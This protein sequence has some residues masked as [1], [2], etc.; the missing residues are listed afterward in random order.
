[1][2]PLAW[3]RSACILPSVTAVWNQS[4]PISS[5]WFPASSMIRIR[6]FSCTTVSRV[7]KHVFTIYVDECLFVLWRPWISFKIAFLLQPQSWNILR[8]S[9]L[10]TGQATIQVKL[11]EHLVLYV[12]AAACSD[13][14]VFPLLMALQTSHTWESSI[15]LTDFFVCL[16]CSDWAI[17][18]ILLAD[19]VVVYSVAS[20]MTLL[21]PLR[22]WS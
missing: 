15:S 2:S 19:T 3:E 11:E 13:F 9:L 20:K 5:C 12:Q 18:A 16:R 8:A 17:W 7:K 10:P 22:S 14:V 21:H 6:L 4:S 1:M